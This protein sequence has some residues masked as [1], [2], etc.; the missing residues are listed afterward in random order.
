MNTV[1]IVVVKF[2]GESINLEDTRGRRTRR[3][4]REIALFCVL[5]SSQLEIELTSY[6]FICEIFVSKEKNH[7]PLKYSIMWR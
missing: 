2:H 3:R 5:L 1:K 4:S 6:P 7:F